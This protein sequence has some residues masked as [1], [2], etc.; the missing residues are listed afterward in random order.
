MAHEIIPVD[1]IQREARESA[2]RFSNVN[3]ACPYPH[4][5][6]AA[7]VFKE[8]FFVAREQRQKGVPA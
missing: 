7:Q 6:T 2:Q 4:Q 8:A 3:D 1:R 5:S